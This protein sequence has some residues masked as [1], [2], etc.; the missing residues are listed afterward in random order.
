MTWNELLE[1]IPVITRGGDGNP[2]ITDIVYD[3]RKANKN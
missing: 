3:S 2:V 1:K